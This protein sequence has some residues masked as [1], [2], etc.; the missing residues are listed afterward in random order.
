MDTRGRTNAVYVGAGEE[1][2]IEDDYANPMGAHRVL[3][4]TW[5]GTTTILEME[6]VAVEESANSAHVRP[7]GPIWT[8]GAPATR[9]SILNLHE[10]ARAGSYGDRRAL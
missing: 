7:A 2:V 3:P 10:W 8:L 5:V 9:T 1:F 6:I 4:K